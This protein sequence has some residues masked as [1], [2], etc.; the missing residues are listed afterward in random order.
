VSRVVRVERAILCAGGG[1]HFGNEFFAGG[2]D[3]EELVHIA[4]VQAERLAWRQCGP[5]RAQT[6]EHL[7]SDWYDQ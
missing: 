4:D 5:H 7:V 6:R 3:A 2:Q 1:I